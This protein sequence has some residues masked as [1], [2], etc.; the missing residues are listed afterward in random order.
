[1]FIQYADIKRILEGDQGI[2]CFQAVVDLR[3]AL[4]SLVIL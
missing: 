4:P 1:M 2:S 3:V